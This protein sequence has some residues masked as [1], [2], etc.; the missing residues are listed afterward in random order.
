MNKN[1]LRIYNKKFNN[2]LSEKKQKTKKKPKN[3]FHLAVSFVAFAFEVPVNEHIRHKPDLLE[4]FFV[5][6]FINTIMGMDRPSDGWTDGL[7]DGLTY[8][9]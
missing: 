4:A 2:T 8:L 5:Y 3:T 7:M 9:S 1:L 6:S